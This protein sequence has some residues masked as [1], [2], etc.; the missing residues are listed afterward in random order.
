[1]FGAIS[2]SRNTEDK[3]SKWVV[4]DSWN[5]KCIIT[6]ELN[7]THKRGKVLKYI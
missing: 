3:N 1:M 5:G 2:Y 4:Y 7:I 6:L